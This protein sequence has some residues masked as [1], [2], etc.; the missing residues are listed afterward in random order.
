MSCLHKYWLREF[1]KIFFIIQLVIL[2]L[3]VAI[4]YLSRM[5]RFLHC[6]I[7]LF[8]A[9]GYVLLKVPFM[10]VQLTPACVL[11]AT[12][13]V[14]GVMNRNNELLA[15]RS[16]GI[17]VYY[18]VRPAVLA[19][20]VL[21]VLI[22]L[23]GETIIPVFTAKANYI[24]DNVIKKQHR[25]LSARRDIWMKSGTRFIHINYFD[26]V[27]K[28]LAGITITGLG[29]NFVIDSRIDAAKGHYTGGKWMFENIVEQTRLPDSMEYHVRTYSK[30][31]IDLDL[32]PEDLGEIVRKSNE[33]SIIAL[34]KYIAKVEHEGYDATVYKVDMNG[35]IAFPF[36]CIIMA[37]TGAATGMKAFVRN[38]MPLGIAV[39]ILIALVYWI[40]YG[41]CL[42]L[43]YGSILPPVISA[44]ITN[45][46]FLSGSILYLMHTE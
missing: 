5:D 45:I 13:I 14:F 30:K 24:H 31:Q 17:S 4:D 8:A 29:K 37:M 46:F 39:G 23:L 41:F 7:S 27:N 6:D 40:M 28:S 3:F 11:L 21:A 25:Y 1:V 20:I 32:N 38:N 2:V 16:S 26:P 44:W 15:V 43:G 12:I 34:K 18:L 42:S 35:K 19:G 22:Y 36:V 33:M 10:F 9:F